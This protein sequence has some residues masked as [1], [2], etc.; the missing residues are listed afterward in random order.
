[1]FST[2]LGGLFRFLKSC[3]D[4]FQT[5]TSLGSGHEYFA[6]VWLVPV[7]YYCTVLVKSNIQGQSLATTTEP[8]PKSSAPVVLCIY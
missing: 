4:S 7:V 1:M 6:W 8:H 2:L 3:T 5:A